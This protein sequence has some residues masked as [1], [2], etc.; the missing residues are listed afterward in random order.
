M[1]L[2][3]YPHA[4][5]R[6]IIEETNKFTTVAAGRRFGKTTA[7]IY[8]ICKVVIDFEEWIAWRGYP[9][10]RIEDF[11]P[12]PTVVVGMP[13]MTMARQIWL[14][15]LMNIF[16]KLPM[17]TESINKSD[18]II[19]TR[20][21]RPNIYIRGVNDQDGDRLRGLK[22][23][24]AMLDEVQDM[25]L[26]IIDGVI[27]PAMVDTPGSQAK[28]IGTPKGKLNVLYKLFQ[29]A[30]LEDYV[31]YHF[32][33]TDN[34]NI[35]RDEIKRA[36]ETLTPRLY[37]QEFEA[38]FLDFEG[39]IYSE[40]QEDNRIKYLPGK[41]DLVVAGYDFG[42]RN[43]AIVV[44]GR[45]NGNWFLLD[46]WQPDAKEPVSDPVQRNKLRELC[47]RHGVQF[48][49]CDPSRPNSILE[50]REEGKKHN[51]Q[52]MTNSLSG[53]NP[54]EEGIQYIHSLIFQ[55]KFFIPDDGSEKFDNYYELMKSY[56]RKIDKKTDIILEKVADGQNDH[57][58]DATR[59]ALA[60]GK[61]G[62]R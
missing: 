58:V 24:A 59:Y 19:Y 6:K 9:G 12:A 20:G 8:W 51:C 45:N 29:R 46:T 1:A 35:P 61:K 18:S 41:Y 7:G 22:I 14:T 44:F 56:H 10:F 57:L 53:F 17:V 48:V 11:N 33:T 28:F 55:K 60:V 2:L 34:P 21:N 16:E 30:E 52:G 32:K 5:Q 15:A 25:N 3:S 36:K 54:I 27:L 37:R 50:L 23:V 40:L 38:N 42:D 62:R 39:S 13:T 26:K 47:L 4:G 43:P 31:S 49:Y